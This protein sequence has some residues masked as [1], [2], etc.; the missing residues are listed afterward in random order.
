MLNHGEKWVE[1]LADFRFNQKLDD[2]TLNK[3]VA[4]IDNNS[5]LLISGST[6]EALIELLKEAGIAH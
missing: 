2:S 1:Y 5:K 6:A 3:D 4:R